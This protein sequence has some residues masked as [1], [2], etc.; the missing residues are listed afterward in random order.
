M[1][2]CEKQEWIDSYLFGE[3]EGEERA[4]FEALMQTDA[5]FCKEVNLQSMIMVGVC[6]Y[7][8]SAKTAKSSVFKVRSLVKRYSVAAAAVFAALLLFK[9]TTEE[10]S[11]YH[12]L[13][14]NAK[15]ERHIEFQ[16]VMPYLI[17][18]P[19]FL[20]RGYSEMATL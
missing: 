19:I 5:D 6:T 9:P 10:I 20:N 7:E 11:S 13:A 3:L 1:N 14:T 8:K 15:Q 2:N 4:H 16:K 12:S 17:P 18:F